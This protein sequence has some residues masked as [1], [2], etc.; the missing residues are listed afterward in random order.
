MDEQREEK[1]AQE[2]RNAQ[3][4]ANNIRNA[5]DV[6]IASKNPYGMAAGA[7]VK[8]ADKLTG[9]K[10]I[11]AAGAGLAK[12]NKMTGPVGNMTQNA[13]NGINES[14]IGN[15]AGQAARLYN[16]AKGGGQSRGSQLAKQPTG[17][18]MDTIGRGRDEPSS[19]LN[20][21]HV[22]PG[23]ANGQKE[24]NGQEE[25]TPP[26]IAGIG[27]FGKQPGSQ[28]EET[29]SNEET[30]AQDTNNSF[31]L[32]GSREA[33]IVVLIAAP[34]IASL[35]LMLVMVAAV[36]TLFGGNFEDAL[37][38]GKASGEDLGTAEFYDGGTK[39]SQEYYERINNVKLSLQAQGKSFNAVDVAS[40]FHVLME[41]GANIDYNDITED[42]ISE[43]ANAMFMGSSYDK[44]HF[45]EE[46]ATRII[47][48]YLPKKTDEEI[49]DLVTEIDQYV[50]DFNEYIEKDDESEYDYRYGSGNCSSTGNCTYDVKG[51]N[52]N[53]RNINKS[54]QINNLKVR[55]MQCGSPYGNGNNNT[56]IKQD[57][58]SFEDYIGGV[59]YAELGDGQPI[60]A[61]KAQMVLARS[62]ALSRP[63]VM[64]NANGKKLSQENGQWVLQIASC[65][66]DQVFCNMDQGCSYMGGGDGQGGWVASGT[67]VTGAAKTR[68]PLPEG[69]E[70]R[71]ALS[72]TQGEV[73]TNS[74][75]YIIGT[76]YNS[77]SQNRMINMA[78]G[79]SDYKQILFKNYTNAKNIDKMSCGSTKCKV[80]TG[81][82]STWKQCGA[83][84]SNVKM[85]NSGNNI[86]N[87]GCLVTS[88]SMLIEKSGVHTNVANFNPGTFVEYLNNSGGFAPGGNFMWYS[89]SGIAPNFKYNRK[90]ELNG[91]SRNDKLSHIKTAVNNGEYLVCEVKGN[92]GQHWVAVDNVS[93]DQVM[94]LDPGSASNNMWQ[95]YSWNNTSECHSYRVG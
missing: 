19:S 78:K 1:K 12:A 20:N 27:A 87:I 71:K 28:K 75:G 45:K 7:A 59:A 60:E 48:Q 47:P 80:S 54:L 4:N 31:K 82:Y 33:K 61:Y 69:S 51:F 57:L 39:D 38:A 42:K 36:S 32:F 5:A 76:G 18:N 66:S 8:A 81:K 50:S 70:L 17:N 67:N 55:L 30:N 91:L 93:G 86:C 13:L 72:A 35:I 21:A 46:L 73:V 16:G 77:T 34:F 63:T 15:R 2:Q 29:T 92:T 94:M 64:G 10:A 6:A 43:V 89:T 3:N 9:G 84:W 53:G 14:G 58:V 37:G 25:N 74:Q 56:P 62:F 88:V 95:E 23:S 40:V 26:R 65:V 68:A 44:E 41:N 49:D 22:Q 85:G 90:I 11:D 83:P 52:V 79:G 24:G